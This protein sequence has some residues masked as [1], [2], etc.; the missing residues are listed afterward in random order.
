M[1]EKIFTKPQKRIW[2]MRW[3]GKQA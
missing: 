3:E 2:E 1:S